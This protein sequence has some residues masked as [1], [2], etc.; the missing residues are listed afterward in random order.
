MKNQGIKEYHRDIYYERTLLNGIIK[1]IYR[2]TYYRFVLD[3]SRSLF[4]EDANKTKKI[5]NY[6]KQG[7]QIILFPSNSIRQRFFNV[8]PNS[9]EEREIFLDVQSAKELGNSGFMLILKTNI[10][11]YDLNWV[12][13]NIL[14]II[15]SVP[16]E[17]F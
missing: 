8:C 1:R 17:E 3:F 2:H 12:D 11:Y 4:P 10:P 14:P 16:G 5:L 13:Q 15:S 6:D 7:H 9:D